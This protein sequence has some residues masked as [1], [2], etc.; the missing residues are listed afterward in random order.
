MI[1]NII[2]HI[3][4]I[5]GVHGIGKTTFC[6]KLIQQLGVDHHSASDLIKR[7]GE[8]D[9]TVNKHTEDI[10]ANQDILIK[11]ISNYI[12]NDSHS[13]LDGHFCLLDKSG[14]VREVPKSTFRKMSAK[15]FIVLQDNP[16]DIATR[17]CHRDGEAPAI[18]T[19]ADFQ[20]QELKYSKQIA[21]HLN[22]P[23]M[24]ANP[25]GNIEPVL[26]FA[27]RVL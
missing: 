9:H 16:H 12:P 8:V 13:L 6:R 21:R 18:D 1:K 24:I 19:I 4:F 10:E 15:A 14:F 23:Y 3:I 17:L 26:A 27:K 11:A 5:G 2:P 7:M 22:I 25:M 20:I